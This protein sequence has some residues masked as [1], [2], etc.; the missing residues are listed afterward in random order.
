MYEAASPAAPSSL[1]GRRAL[2][3]ERADSPEVRDA[4]RTRPRDTN[5]PFDEAV[6][7]ARLRRWQAER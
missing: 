1:P 6:R 7:L 2:P 4:L 5:L 3:P